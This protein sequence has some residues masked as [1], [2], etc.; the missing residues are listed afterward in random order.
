MIS[1]WCRCDLILSRVAIPWSAS[2][3][4]M[5]ACSDDSI[6]QGTASGLVCASWITC[7]LRSGCIP[8]KCQPLVG[9]DS[10]E[11]SDSVE[12]ARG[13]LKRFCVDVPGEIGRFFGKSLKSE[14]WLVYDYGAVSCLI[15]DFSF[16]PPGRTSL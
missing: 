5:E 12:D 2:S 3:D 10:F 11:S 15:V 14:I 13:L 9:V 1:D 8:S 4:A 16:S 7:C 6:A